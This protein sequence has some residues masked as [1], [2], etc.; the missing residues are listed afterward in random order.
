MSRNILLRRSRLVHVLALI[1]AS[2]LVLGACGAPNPAASPTAKPSTPVSLTVSV[3]QQASWVRNFNPL[4]AEK[5]QRWPARAGIYEPLMIY[6]T[7]TG[8]YVPWLATEYAW[9]P[10]NL[11]LTLTTHDGVKWSDGQLFTAKDVAFTFQL[12][13]K[14]KEAD[15]NGVW[16]FLADVKATNDRTVEFT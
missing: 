3:E 4:L 5:S 9:T 16:G 10:D 12:L 8:K 1:T 13:K 6:N 15:L 14:V 7:V 11:K 2:V